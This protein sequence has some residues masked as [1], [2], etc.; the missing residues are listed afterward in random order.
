MFT[1]FLGLSSLE[2]LA[3]ICVDH[4]DWLNKNKALGFKFS[5]SFLAR[6][7][8]V[9]ATHSHKICTLGQENINGTAVLHTKA[10]Q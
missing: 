9:K 8:K 4:V 3:L 7:R 2:F 10:A 6:S 5:L 1:P